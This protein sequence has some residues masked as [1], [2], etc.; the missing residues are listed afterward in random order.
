ML[1]VRDDVFKKI[2]SLSGGEKSKLRLVSLLFEKPNLLI[3]DEPTNH[4]D[5]DS[6]EVLEDTLAEY[7]GTLLFVSHDRYFVKSLGSK[8]LIIN[9]KS[10][11]LYP[12]PYDDYLEIKK[13]QELENVEKQEEKKPKKEKTQAKRKPNNTYRM[14]KLEEKILEL[15]ARLDLLAKEMEVNNDKADKLYELYAENE[16]I[17]EELLQAYEEWESLQV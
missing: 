16:K 13:R 10:A 5:I 4:L 14:N 6:R 12:V 7:E 2:K 9:N 3:L 8:M 17:E 11:Q 1:F 15:E